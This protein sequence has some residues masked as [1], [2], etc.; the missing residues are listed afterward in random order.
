MPRKNPMLPIVNDN[1][2]IT[3]FAVQRKYYVAH[4]IANALELRISCT[5]PSIYHDAEIH[6]I[7]SVEASETEIGGGIWRLWR[8]GWVIIDLSPAFQ[9]WLSMI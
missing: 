2:G 5:N 7:I 1:Q 4:I 8:I 9:K 3:Y 6:S